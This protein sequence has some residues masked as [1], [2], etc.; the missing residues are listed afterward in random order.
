MDQLAPLYS[1]TEKDRFFHFGESR[2]LLSDA[3]MLTIMQRMLSTID[4]TK[5]ADIALTLLGER[6]TVTGL[7]IHAPDQ[8]YATGLAGVYHRQLEAPQQLDPRICVTYRFAR[9]PSAHEERLLH[10]MHDCIVTPLA[11]AMAH[12]RLANMATKDH[13]TGLGNRA[14][15]DEALQR[16][17]SHA[18]RSGSRFGL[19]VIDMDKFKLINDQYGHQEGDKVLISVA[20]AI[21]DCLRDTDFAFRFG[22]D[23]FCC[24][25]EDADAKALLCI[26]QRIRRAMNSYPVLRQYNASCSIGVSLYRQGDTSESLFERA[27]LALYQLKEANYQGVESA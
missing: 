4:I 5:L 21:N 9:K 20:R 23:E 22:G 3:D 24:L 15:F 25:I 16:L 19:V 14:S 27:D 1:G 2:R 7:E 10:E 8:G 18:N 11:H 6:L 17:I 26:G 12:A 13:L